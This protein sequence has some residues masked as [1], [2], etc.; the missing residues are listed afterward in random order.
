MA[1]ATQ[2]SDDVFLRLS[3]KEARTLFG[4][5]RFVGGDP[6]GLRGYT[7]DIHDELADALDLGFENYTTILLDEDIEVVDQIRG[8][9]RIEK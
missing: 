3:E 8:T 5:L 1:D 9:L 4:V 7:Q 6:E 2:T